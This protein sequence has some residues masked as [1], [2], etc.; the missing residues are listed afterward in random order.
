V[1]DEADHEGGRAGVGSDRLAE[2]YDKGRLA[3]QNVEEAAH[4]IVDVVGVA[5][6]DR[7]TFNPVP[8]MILDVV[9]QLAHRRRAVFGLPDRD[10]V[11]FDRQHMTKA[12]AGGF[13]FQQTGPTAPAA[14]RAGP[15]AGSQHRR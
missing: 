13:P 3:T 9:E 14:G 6:A 10:D 4:E 8:N 2:G 7:P 1:G 15:T 12:V 5:V 11:I